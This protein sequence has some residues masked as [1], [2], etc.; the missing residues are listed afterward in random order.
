MEERFTPQMFVEWDAKQKGLTKED[1]GVAPVVVLTWSLRTAQSMAKEIDAKISIHWPY[2]ERF[3]IYSGHIMDRPVS[4]AYLPVGAPGTV[5][6]MEEMIAC[7]ARIL[8][9]LG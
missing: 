2:G 9:G 7:G 4:F 1:F 6:M 5:M 3:P 8:I